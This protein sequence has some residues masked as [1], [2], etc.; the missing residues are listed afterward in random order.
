[1]DLSPL[2]QGEQKNEQPQQVSSHSPSAQHTSWPPTVYRPHSSHT[3]TEQ[4]ITVSDTTQMTTSTHSHSSAHFQSSISAN[5]EQIEA[6]P[7]DYDCLST[8]PAK[9]VCPQQLNSIAIC[10]HP[11]STATR[12]KTIASSSQ[13][14][15]A[16]I[17]VYRIDVVCCIADALSKNCSLMELTIK[18]TGF[19]GWTFL[20]LKAYIKTQR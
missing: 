16:G 6:S 14:I 2:T 7:Q 4:C 12:S 8:P 5:N 20:Y 3:R 15:P 18:N 11:L 17:H 13:T 19:L 10:T 9:R 1:M